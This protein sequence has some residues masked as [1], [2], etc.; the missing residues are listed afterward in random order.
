M[1]GTLGGDADKLRKAVGK[2]IPS[3]MKKQQEK[4]I[5]GCMKN[6]ISRSKAEDIFHLIEPFAGYGFNKAHAACYG[7]IA[8][9]TAYLKANYPVE[10]MTAVLSAE[11]RA[12]TGD[13]RNDKIAMIVSECKRMDVAILRPDVNTSDIEFSV[14]G[15]NIRFGLSAIKMSALR[16][17][18][19]FSFQDP[20]EYLKDCRIS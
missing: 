16:R 19:A 13:T 17:W 8:Y 4:F 10:Y 3:E 14:E 5:D 11:S 9:Q 1:L 20:M 6:G 12:N 18:R 7:M 15:K 2:K